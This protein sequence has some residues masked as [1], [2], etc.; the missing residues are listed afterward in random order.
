MLKHNRLASNSVHNRNYAIYMRTTIPSIPSLSL[1]ETRAD[2]DAFGF[3]L[4]PRFS[5]AEL[6]HEFI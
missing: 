4:Q 3:L 2:I 6:G 1:G 5:G